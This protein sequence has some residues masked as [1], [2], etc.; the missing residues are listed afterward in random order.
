MDELKVTFGEWEYHFDAI[1]GYWVCDEDNTTM[2]TDSIAKWL[3]HD[4]MVIHDRALA[5]KKEEG[6][7]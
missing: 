5:P 2:S 3:R 7:E 6:D 1:N 4:A